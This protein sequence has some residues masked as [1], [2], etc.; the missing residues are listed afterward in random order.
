MTRPGGK[1][2]LQGLRAVCQCLPDACPGHVPRDQRQGLLLPVGGA[3]G[4]VQRAAATACSCARTWPSRWSTRARP[5]RGPRRSSTSPMH[6]CPGCTHGVIHRLV[7]EAMDALDIRERTVGVAP[8]GCSV[9]AYD[10]FNCDM[11]EASHGRAMAVA[12]GH[13]ARPAR[14]DR[15]QL[16][17]R[18]RPGLHRHGGDH[19]RRQPRRE[20]HGDLRQQRHLRHDRRPDGADHPAGPG[21]LDQPGGPGCGAGRLSHPRRRA[22]Q[23]TEDPR[24]SGAGLHARAQGHPAGAQSHP[25]RLP[26]SGGAAPASRWSRSSPPARPGW[27][28]QPTRPAAGWRST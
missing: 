5:P 17:G 9:L 12:T 7:A 8:V 22:A 21:G 26:A 18:R 15:L 27:G 25:D 14:P 10:Y 19:P 1:G 20:D 24:L 11:H 4:R 2:P 13:Q 3:R 28:L 16:P 23:G 6:Y